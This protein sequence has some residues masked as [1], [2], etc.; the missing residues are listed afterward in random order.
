M[1]RTLKFLQMK[2][3]NR[4]KLPWVYGTIRYNSV[5]EPAVTTVSIEMS[6]V[7]LIVAIILKVEHFIE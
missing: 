5:H 4:S 1:G 3:V 2:P 7:L 6:G